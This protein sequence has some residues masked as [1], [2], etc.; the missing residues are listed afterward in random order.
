MQEWDLGPSL[1]E[2]MWR[3]R[4]LV[5]LTVI[6]AAAAGFGLSYLQSTM[7]EGE[8][9]LI[10]SD[11]RNAGVFRDESRLVIDPSRYVRNQAERINSTEVL[12]RAALLESGRI[13]V[14]TLRAR[15]TVSPSTNLDLITIRALDPTPEGAAQLADSVG[16]AYEEIVAEEATENAN[17]ALAEL[18]R[19]LADTQIQI[20]VLEARL[21]AD[22]EDSVAKA[23]RDAAV[24]Q[25][26]T[27][28]NRAEQIS[29]D[30]ALYGSGV[31]L[32][33][34]SEIPKS[35]ASPKPLRN[36]AVAAM[37]G[38]L[39]VGAYAWWK[40]ERTQTAESRHDPA[41][42][43][44]A[45]LLGEIPDF[46]AVGAEGMIPTVTAPGSTVAEA[47]QFVVTSLEFA[48]NGESSTVVITSAE[49]GDGKT[50]SAMNLAVA[51]ARDGRKVLLVDAD[52][53]VRGLTRYSGGAP[54]PGLTD[55][56][57][58]TISIEACTRTWPIDDSLSVPLIPAGATLD[59]AAGFFRTGAFR[60]AMKQ[61]RVGSDIVLIDTPPILAVSDTSA[62]AGQADGIVL[63]VTK[64]T[65]LRR[66]EDVR[67][68]LE[69]VG[70]PLLG[71]IFNRSD[72]NDR[73]YGYK[74][75]YGYG[76]GYGSSPDGK[77]RHRRS[78]NDGR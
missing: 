34:H 76:Y 18:D 44:G 19:S 52:E 35:P 77:S 62:V 50:V 25:L 40:A 46:A 64:G 69:F 59:D 7:Y 2:S 15:V 29:V 66:L 24:A 11:P 13:S 78:A 4:R 41:P 45:P 75:G 67:D 61:I 6:I 21:D 20:D 38:L 47:Y 49:P 43:L 37:L 73:S 51:A 56:A 10:L 23:E 3:F 16:S 55:L 70:T 74:S 63:V 36:A 42:V 60:D 27:L 39:G 28:K 31:Q 14:D 33:E 53:R 8:T 1:L 5:I 72:P 17:A 32:F 71:Y 9:G 30:A 48:L 65:P 12:T 22:P 57:G 54:V 58:G 26:V 68:R